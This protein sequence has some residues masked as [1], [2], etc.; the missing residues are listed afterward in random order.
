MADLEIGICD[1]IER[2]VAETFKPAWKAI[3]RHKWI[4]HSNCKPY[5]KTYGRWNK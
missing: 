1:A 4:S 3:R 5:R 2:M